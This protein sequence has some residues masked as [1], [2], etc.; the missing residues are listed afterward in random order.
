[1]LK[2][3]LSKTVHKIIRI[4]YKDVGSFSKIFPLLIQEG[5]ES[6]EFVCLSTYAMSVILFWLIGYCLLFLLYFV[7]CYV[8]FKVVLFIFSIIW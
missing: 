7:I 1:M 6:I 2:N 5:K 3:L 8:L 4:L